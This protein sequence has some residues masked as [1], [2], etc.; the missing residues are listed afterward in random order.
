MQ[1]NFCDRCGTEIQ[2][3]NWS[4]KIRI[5]IETKKKGIEEFLGDYELCN[6]CGKEFLDFIRKSNSKEEE[7]ITQNKPKTKYSR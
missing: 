1:K 5:T 7:G 2:T 4:K 6:D 3:N